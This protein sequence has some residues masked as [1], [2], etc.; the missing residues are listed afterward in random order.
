MSTRTPHQVR[1]LAEEKRLLHDHFGEERLL[2]IGPTTTEPKVQVK[3]TS[4]IRKKIYIF[5]LYIPEDFPNHC[6]KLAIVSPERLSRRNGVLLGENSSEFHTLEHH[7]GFQTICHFH[8]ADWHCGFR[9]FQVFTKA[10]LWMEAS[11]SHLNN[12]ENLQ[13]YL[14]RF[15]QPTEPSEVSFSWSPAQ[16]KRLQAEREQLD[17]FYPDRIT[18]NTSSCEHTTVDIEIKTAE[19]GNVY[20]LQVHLPSDYPNSCPT[21]AVV[22]PEDLRCNGGEPLPE[23]SSEFRTLGKRDGKMTICHCSASEWTGDMSIRGVFTKGEIWV[24]AYESYKM[25]NGVFSIYLNEHVQSSD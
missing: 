8:S 25:N 23:N 13:H 17:E 15:L 5:R 24:K 9:L 12:G 21:L 10:K 19:N 16:I 22:S 4:I 1:R 18:W 6:P 14:R 3:M 7:D 2:W 20:K 11:E